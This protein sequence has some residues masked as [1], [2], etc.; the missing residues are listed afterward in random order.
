MTSGRSKK[1]DSTLKTPTKTIQPK[2][3]VISD[4][5]RNPRTESTA[6][7]NRWDEYWSDFYKYPL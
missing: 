4:A 6:V 7:V 2:V 3:S 5:D 1:A